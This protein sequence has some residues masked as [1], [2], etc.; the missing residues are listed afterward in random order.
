L[1]HPE[2][3]FA[4]D[5]FFPDDEII[6]F[7]GDIGITGEVNLKKSYKVENYHNGNRPQIKQADEHDNFD[8]NMATLNSSKHGAES[9]RNGGRSITTQKG[10]SPMNLH[11]QTTKLER[12]VEGAADLES[13]CSP[14]PEKRKRVGVGMT[15]GNL[16]N[17]ERP[18]PKAI[19]ETKLVPMQGKSS[20][21]LLP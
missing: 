1:K 8:F 3:A 14:R 7:P 2:T 15:M 11:I 6:Y 12:I 10:K 21:I 17:S 19:T 5:L 4:Y 9:K 13:A 16:F 18:S 20:R